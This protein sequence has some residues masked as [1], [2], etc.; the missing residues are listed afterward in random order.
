MAGP[1]ATTT[2]WSELWD[3]VVAAN[4]AWSGGR[5]EDVALLFH[6]DAVMVVPDG[7]R[8]AGRDA[9][10]ASVT[11]YTR[12]ARTLSFVEEAPVVE[13]FGDSAV[14]TYAFRVKYEL[15]GKVAEER[16]QEVLV[17]ARREGRWG[18]VWRTQFPLPRAG[19]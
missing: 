19:R 2:S 7:P 12:A 8:L 17:F 16:G 18:A 6:A 11:E 15:G 10:V 14:V 3:L 9:I 1:G 4:R 5:P 13:L